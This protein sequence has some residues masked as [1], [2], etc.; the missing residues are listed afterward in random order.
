M[1]TSRIA[2]LVAVGGIVLPLLASTASAVTA[3]PRAAPPVGTRLAILKGSDTVAGDNF[4]S[5]V[6]ISGST[7]VVSARV[8]PDNTNFIGR[9]YVFTRT[10][11]GWKQVA[12]LKGP[13]V[14]AGD[15][16]GNSVAISGTTIVVGAVAA[17]RACVFTKTAFG[18]TQVAELKGS[19]T[20]AAD[21]FGN[22]VAISGTTAVVGAP[23]HAKVAGRAYVFTETAA[24]W[25]QTAELKGT[26]TVAGDE[27]GFS[28]AISGTTAI[29]GASGSAK[30]LGR[31]YV[32]T[33]TGAG[34]KQTTELK[35]SHMGLFGNSVAISGTT[36]V[37]G[38]PGYVIDDAG[39]AYVFTRTASGWKQVAELKGSDT[40][41]GD[42]FGYSVAISGTTAV[43][44]ANPLESSPNTIGRAYLFTKTA[45]GWKQIAE[46]KGPHM[47]L[48]GNSVAISGTTVMVGA[49]NANNA[50]GRTY[51]FDA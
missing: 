1:R 24:G 10:G 34:W 5:S 49:P 50:A 14:I 29:V 8:H 21:S 13:D 19:D 42:W 43:V 33:K 6:A 46:L 22:S 15:Y 35:G 12:E 9:A 20:V 39:R 45:T 18:W 32:F 28:V 41:A 25:T 23:I 48:F 3:S 38:A 27:F 30:G 16:F 37:V 47:G 40:V 17:S 26:D 44:S 2:S 4:A 7:A 51:V 36:A 31:A 11:S